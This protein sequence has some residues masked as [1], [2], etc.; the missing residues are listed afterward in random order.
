MDGKLQKYLASEFEMKDLGA[1]KYFLG[2]EITRSATSIFLSQNKYVLDLLIETGMLGFAPAE[3]P[4][5]QNL[6]AIYHDQ[7]STNKERYQRLVGRLIYLSHTRPDIAYAISV[8]SQFMHPPSEDHLV[9]VMRILSYLKKTPGRD[10]IFRKLGHLD[11]K[12]YIDADW[13][14]NITDRSCTSSYFTFIGGNLV[15][16]RSK[17]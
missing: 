14:G 9:T 3:T 5:V 12:G 13:A 7:V 17:K 6:L 15:I 10:L 1:L 8:V 11:V 4:I 2:I 16:W